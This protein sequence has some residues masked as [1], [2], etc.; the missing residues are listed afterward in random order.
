MD[1]NG[2]ISHKV[3][4][5]ETMLTYLNSCGDIG[6]FQIASSELLVSTVHSVG[7]TNESQVVEHSATANPLVWVS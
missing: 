6:E 5:S 1:L 2:G 7:A 3:C 4:L